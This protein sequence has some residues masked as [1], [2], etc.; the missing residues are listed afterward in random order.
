MSFKKMFWESYLT[1]QRN[2]LKSG[3][4]AFANYL[5]ENNRYGIKFSQQIVSGWLN[6]EFKPSEKYILALADIM[7]DEIYDVLDVPHPDPDL[8]ILVRLWPH[9]TEDA[10]RKLRAQGERYL[11]ANEKRILSESKS[12]KLPG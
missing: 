10:R 12:S 11:A 9:L 3:F 1:F 6:G 4:T 7:G 2:T 8:Q 5:T